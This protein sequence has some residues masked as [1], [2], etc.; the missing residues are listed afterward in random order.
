AGNRRGLVAPLEEGQ[1]LPLPQAPRSEPARPGGLQPL[2][3]RER[4]RR[5]LDPLNRMAPAQAGA[6]LVSRRL[7][8]A[9]S[10]EPHS[11]GSEHHARGWPQEK[12]ACRSRSS[13]SSFSPFSGGFCYGSAMA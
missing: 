10:G 7:I 11:I 3:K 9:P 1:R 6:S 12:V 8:G 13:P 2:Q 5:P 4:S